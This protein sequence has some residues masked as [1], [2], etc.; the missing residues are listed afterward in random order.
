M[1]HHTLE[2][3]FA[4]KLHHSRG[5][6]DGRNNSEVA[7]TFVRY[8]CIRGPKLSPIEDI[9]GLQAELQPVSFGDLEILAHSH[10][11]VIRARR[12]QY[13]APRVAKGSGRIVGKGG[14]IEVL[15]EVVR[16]RAFG[17]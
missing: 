7:D 8:V 5:I 2:V 1:G 10:V 16:A 14:R 17:S 15:N 3:K 9:E 12:L 4:G 11:P 13:V 6:C